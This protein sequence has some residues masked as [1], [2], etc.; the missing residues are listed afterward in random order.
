MD[1]AIKALIKRYKDAVK[2]MDD[3]NVPVADKEKY[4]PLF[5]EVERD[6]KLLTKDMSVEQ[7]DK[8]MNDAEVSK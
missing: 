3:M 7:I 4:L 5:L 6:V 8:M 1:E 2:Y